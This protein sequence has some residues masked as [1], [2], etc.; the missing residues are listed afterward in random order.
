MEHPQDRG[1]RRAGTDIIVARRMSQERNLSGAHQN[2]TSQAGRYR[3]A[4]L[5]DCQCWCC[6]G[7]WREHIGVRRSLAAKEE[8]G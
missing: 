2:W 8:C 6:R 3:K 1:G 5:F 4:H 7:P